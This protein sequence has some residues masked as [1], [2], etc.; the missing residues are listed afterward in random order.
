VK[1]DV[2][3]EMAGA[4]ASSALGVDEKRLFEA[5][6]AREKLRSTGIGEGVAIPHCRFPDLSHPVI[7]FAR[8]LEGVDFDSS[9]EQPTHL[10][11]LLAVPD[12][13]SGHHLR[14]LARISRY[15]HDACFRKRLSEAETR[16]DVCRAVGHEDA[17]F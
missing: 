6:S 15:L 17:K 8:S 5:L 13:Y 3:A 14:A 11:F 12:Q 10:F 2:L 4:L 7:S 9:D 16:E 1:R